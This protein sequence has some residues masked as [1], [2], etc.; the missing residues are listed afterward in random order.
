ML[1]AA[2]SGGMAIWLSTGGLAILTGLT[3]SGSAVLVVT[4]MVSATSGHWLAGR[5][6]ERS[7]GDARE[8]Q[9]RGPTE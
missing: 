6:R 4:T 1:L 5:M 9:D 8:V 2:E 3:G 7:G